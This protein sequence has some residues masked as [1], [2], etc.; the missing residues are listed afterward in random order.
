ML[1]MIGYE[2]E[3]MKIENMKGRGKLTISDFLAMWLE[4]LFHGGMQPMNGFKNEK[5]STRTVATR[6]T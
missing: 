3:D 4:Y 2:Q 1:H 6:C 5:F